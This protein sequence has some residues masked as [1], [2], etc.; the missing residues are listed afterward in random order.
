[1]NGIHDMGGMH[2]FGSVEVEP[3]E[4]VFHERWQGRVFGMVQALRGGNI[5]AGRHSLERLDP[6]AYLEHGYYGRWLAAFERGLVRLGI[7]APGEM[8]ARM[9]A[10]R[11]RKPRAAAARPAWAPVATNFAREVGTRPAFVVGDPVTARNHQPAGHTRLPAYVRCR[12][13]I[14]A[15]VH[16]AMVF[17]DDNA[18]GRGENPQY[19]YTVRFDGRELWGA[20]AEAGTVVHIDLFESYLDR[21]GS[22]TR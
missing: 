18:H 6:V 12:T 7:V 22:A 17:P 8:E 9:K 2:G 21:A 4:P 19:L 5:D 11:R 16:A 1:M 14:V 13:G 15:R 10:R 20:D 3:N